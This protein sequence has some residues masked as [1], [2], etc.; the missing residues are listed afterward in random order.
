[1]PTYQYKREDG[2]TFE[3]L[4]RITDEPLKTCPKTDLKVKRIITGGG[5]VIY[6][7]SGW[8]VTDYKNK[9]NGNSPAATA[10]TSSNGSGNNGNGSSSGSVGGTNEHSKAS[11]ANGG[12]S[13]RTNDPSQPASD[14]S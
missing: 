13:S 12:K 10:N 11:S 4:Q 1:M 2:T 7:G 8:Y 5:G 6:K 3:I 9:P 14:K